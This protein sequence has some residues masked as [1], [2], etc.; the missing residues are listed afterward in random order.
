MALSLYLYPQMAFH[1]ASLVMPHMQSIWHKSLSFQEKPGAIPSLFVG[2][3]DVYEVM[4]GGDFSPL[5]PQKKLNRKEGKMKPQN[6]YPFFH[7][8]ISITW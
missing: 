3:V 6:N 8:G 2:G 5:L 7:Y 4:T 1:Q